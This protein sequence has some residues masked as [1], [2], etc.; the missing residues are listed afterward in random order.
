MIE[1]SGEEQA[2]VGIGDFE[3]EWGYT[4]ELVIKETK[5]DPDLQ[6]APALF[7]D[8]VEV[9]SKERVAPGT[10][11]ETRLETVL[12]VRDIGEGMSRQIITREAPDLFAFFKGIYS[13]EDADFGREFTC[14][15]A[16]CEEMSDL[17]GQELELTLRFAHPETPNQPLVLEQIVS[18][19]ALPDWY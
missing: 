4:Y 15:P 2:V 11:F 1:P 9:V 10:T 16:L 19:E 14:E 6:D 3:Y 5:P 18:T 8:L 17:V 7:R 13:Y 12:P